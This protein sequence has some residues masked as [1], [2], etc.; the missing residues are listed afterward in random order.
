MKKKMQLCILSKTIE[1]F[2]KKMP[3]KFVFETGKYFLEVFL[4][5]FCSLKG[6]PS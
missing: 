3:T 6:F 2:N 5:L 1:I 4:Y